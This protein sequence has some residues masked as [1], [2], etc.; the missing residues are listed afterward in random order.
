MKTCNKCGQLQSLDK[1]A[2]CA[3]NSDGRQ[4]ICKK[5]GKNYSREPAVKKR[6]LINKDRK[7]VLQKIRKDSDIQIYRR[8]I[9]RNRLHS[10]LKENFEKSKYFELIGMNC[11][12]LQKYIQSQWSTGMSWDNYG[13]KQNHWHLSFK[14]PWESLDLA[15][16]DE[17]SKAIHHTNVF[18]AWFIHQDE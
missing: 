4:Y 17:F 3:R 12:G 9:I 1:F 7:N 13:F 16:D 11:A 18:P 2:K 8:E 10:F 15:K 6:S 5:C 14:I